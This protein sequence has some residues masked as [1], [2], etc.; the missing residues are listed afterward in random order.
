MSGLIVRSH[1]TRPFST[2][3]RNRHR[4]AQHLSSMEDL[5]HLRRS[6][7]KGLSFGGNRRQLQRRSGSHSCMWP[8]RGWRQVL[9][10]GAG[11]VEGTDR[12]DGYSGWLERRVRALSYNKF[13]FPLESSV[14]APNAILPDVVEMWW[15]ARLDKAMANRELITKLCNRK[16]VM[17]GA[18]IIRAG[19]F[20]EFP[21]DTLDLRV[22]QPF[23]P[24]CRIWPAV[25]AHAQAW[26]RI[27]LNWGG[28]KVLAAIRDFA[29]S[30]CRWGVACRD[31]VVAR[32]KGVQKSQFRSTVAT[33]PLEAPPLVQ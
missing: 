10:T 7:R 1:P 22:P 19:I 12:P 21:R 4:I 5:P 15:E 26:N 32:R 2:G 17:S 31:V 28:K 20:E 23:F 9:H 11:H 6:P 18:Q 33:A 8:P 13:G 27:S 30:R 16:H 14:R 3:G 29:M 25:T 24:L